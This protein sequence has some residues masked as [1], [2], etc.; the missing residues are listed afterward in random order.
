MPLGSNIAWPDPSEY[1]WALQNRSSAFYDPDIQSGDLKLIAGRP[2]R[3]NGGG[4]KYICVYKVG[5]W[6]VRCFAAQPPNIAPP[7]EIQ[8]RYRAITSYLNRPRYASDF[9]FFARPIL[10]ERGLHLNGQD[11]PFVKI[12]FVKDSQALGDFLV[13]HYQ[14]QQA[15]GRLAELWLNV[16]QRMEAYQVAH[17]DLDMSN[18]LV[19]G[20]SPYLSLKLIDFD[21]MYV[22]DMARFRWNVADTGHAHFQPAQ[23]NIRRFG[24]ELDRFSVLIIYITLVALAKNPAL[25]ENCDADETRPL[26]GAEDFARLGL[27]Q[28]FIRLSQE[29]N[30]TELQQCLQELQNSIM[31]SRMPRSLGEILHRGGYVMRPQDEPQAGQVLPEY[32]GR[33]L[34]IP[35]EPDQDQNKYNSPPQGYTPPQPQRYGPPPTTPA[36]QPYGQARR[37]RGII[38]FVIIILIALGLLIWWLVAH[39]HSQTYTFPVA[40]ALLLLPMSCHRLPA[41]PPS[42]EGASYDGS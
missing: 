31:Q 2:A 32:E 4:S 41:D 7:P 38:I 3:L 16:V 36:S 29:R 14:D 13:D 24:P 5:D 26:L 23:S 42:C 10:V 30:N 35:V 33:A 9:A 22:P 11:L 8:L 1:D 37:S 39:S 19:C 40:Q 21:G 17:G 34:V 12:D 6:V 18:V 20:T 27:S 15:T 28:N 25:W